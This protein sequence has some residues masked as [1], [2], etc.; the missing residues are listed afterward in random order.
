MR[1]INNRLMVASSDAVSFFNIDTGR[2]SRIIKAIFQDEEITTCEYLPNQNMLLLVNPKG[3][4]KGVDADNG[5]LVLEMQLPEGKP[6]RLRYEDHVKML[7]YSSDEAIAM[8]QHDSKRSAFELKREIRHHDDYIVIADGSCLHDL[9]AFTYGGNVVYFYTHE[10]ARALGS[11][12]APEPVVDL[13]FVAKHKLIALLSETS[14]AV[15]SYEVSYGTITTT[16]K[17][18][19]EDV[20]AGKA[21]SARIW[22]NTNELFVAS[23]TGHLLII[24]NTFQ[25]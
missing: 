14:L 21:I 22:Q 3:L 15:M 7:F 2:V 5:G 18:A 17:Y 4:M 24:N 10:R 16:V 13:L 1:M 25:G 9:V 12:L 23:A 20:W 6:I 8:Y 19:I 11:L